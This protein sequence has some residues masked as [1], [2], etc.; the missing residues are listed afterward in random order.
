MPSTP[1]RT[2]KTPELKFKEYDTTS[3]STTL[4]AA[5]LLGSG[6][7]AISD[8]VSDFNQLAQLHQSMNKTLEDAFTHFKGKS[9]RA[10]MDAVNTLRQHLI[11]RMSAKKNSTTYNQLAKLIPDSEDKEDNQQIAKINQAIQKFEAEQLKIEKK[12][13][14]NPQLQGTRNQQTFNKR[15]TESLNKLHATAGKNQQKKD[16]IAAMMQCLAHNCDLLNTPQN[17][18]GLHNFMKTIGKKMQES[19]YAPKAPIPEKR[20]RPTFCSIKMLDE[21]K[22]RKRHVGSKTKDIRFDTVGLSAAEMEVV[23]DKLQERQPEAVITRT[24]DKNGNMSYSFKGPGVTASSP[25]TASTFMSLVQQAK[26]GQKKEGKLNTEPTHQTSS[27]QTRRIRTEESPTLMRS[28]TQHHLQAQEAL[29]RRQQQ[30]NAQRATAT[31]P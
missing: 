29:Q 14:D 2:P 22:L 21:K 17:D 3:L 5:G 24:Y 11:N 20:R 8:A 13:T 18:G 28:T 26:K 1:S 10:S 6:K 15:L 16:E 30:E 4:D 27:L 9:D 25:G 7:K 12:Y 31:T 19:R 23:L